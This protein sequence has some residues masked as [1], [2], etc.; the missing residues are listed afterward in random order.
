MPKNFKTRRNF[1]LAEKFYKTKNTFIT[2]HCAFPHTP[3]ITDVSL[4]PLNQHVAHFSA[5]LSQPNRPHQ[6]PCTYQ[7]YCNRENVHRSSVQC[8][9]PA[10]NKFVFA[11]LQ[12]DSK[13]DYKTILPL[14]AQSCVCFTLKIRIL[15]VVRK[16]FRQDLTL[17]KMSVATAPGCKE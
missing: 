8:P 2:N 3:H 6:P 4:Q 12:V 5:K 1:I 15:A 9:W 11:H 17:R 14:Q 10:I 7:L 13:T 16:I